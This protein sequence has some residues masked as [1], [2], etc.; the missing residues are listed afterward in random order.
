MFWPDH[1][2]PFDVVALGERRQHQCTECFIA[3]AGALE[4]IQERNVQ[5][6][7]VDVVW[8]AMIDRQLVFY[9]HIICIENSCQSLITCDTIVQI[10]NHRR[11]E[12]SAHKSGQQAVELLFQKCAVF[13]QKCH[14][15]VDQL[16]GGCQNTNMIGIDQWQKWKCGA[17][18]FVLGHC[19]CCEYKE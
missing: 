19:E 5:V 18:D 4:L 10:E 16:F 17:N 7:E 15:R 13:A 1:L 9:L 3:V 6:L 11:R 2:T 12:R 8:N 14:H